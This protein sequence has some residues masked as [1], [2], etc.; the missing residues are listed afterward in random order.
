MAEMHRDV[1]EMALSEALVIFSLS[2]CRLSLSERELQ[3]PAN[4]TEVH[5]DRDTATILGNR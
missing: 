2:Q 1:T 5:W 3:N 4:A